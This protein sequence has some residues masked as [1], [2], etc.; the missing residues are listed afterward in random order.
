MGPPFITRRKRTF[1]MMGQV[2]DQDDIQLVPEP[3]NRTRATRISG[4][5]V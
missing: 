2:R 5:V 1:E 4:G 3:G